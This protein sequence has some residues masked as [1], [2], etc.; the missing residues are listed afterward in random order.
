MKKLNFKD[1][2]PSVIG[3]VQAFGITA[4]VVLLT[5]TVNI[6]SHANADVEPP[7][8]LGMMMVLLLFVVSA[9]ITGSLGFGY[10]TLLALRKD[11]NRAVAVVGW[12]VLWL[13]LITLTVVGLGL[14]LARPG[15]N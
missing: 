3:F 9:A 10:A 2:S 1:Y 11:F 12:T 13:I 6:I 14:A 4:Y 15:I 7:V 5:A 8:M